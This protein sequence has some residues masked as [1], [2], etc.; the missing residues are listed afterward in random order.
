MSLE[1]TPH[2]IIFFGR[3]DLDLDLEELEIKRDGDNRWKVMWLDYPHPMA[4]FTGTFTE[5]SKALKLHVIT[6]RMTR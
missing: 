2:G 1:I 6:E 5:A 3:R 4:K